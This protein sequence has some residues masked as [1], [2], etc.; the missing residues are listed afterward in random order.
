VNDEPN[1]LVAN[2]AMTAMLSA[3]IN[4]PN[5]LV[6]DGDT[7]TLTPHLDDATPDVTITARTAAWT[8][9]LMTPPRDRASLPPG[10]ELAGTRRAVAQFF[11]LLARF[12]EGI[13]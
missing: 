7:W 2:S 5:A 8:R 9:F 13:G 3:A 12:P 11:R 6:V 10:I 4:R 1:I